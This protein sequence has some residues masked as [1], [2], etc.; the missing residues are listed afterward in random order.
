[1]KQLRL[2]LF[3]CLLTAGLT[4]ISLPAKAAVAETD[5]GIF[6]SIRDNVVTVE[7]FNQ[8]GTVLEV[9]AQIEGLPVRYVAPYACRGNTAITEVRLPDSLLSIGEF[10]FADC[11]NLLKV[12]LQGGES[13]GFSAFRNCRVLATLSLP[14]TLTVIDDEAFYGCT[15]LSFARIP[16]SVSIIGVDAFAGCDRLRLD[17]SDN[18]L[19]ATYAKQYRIPTRFTETPTFTAILILAASLALSVGYL[20]VRRFFPTR[21]PRGSANLPQHK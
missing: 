16:A 12:T 3:L 14:D 1:M 6:Y 15:R 18:A 19:A 5:S 10:A 17:V 13:I 21:K 9:P 11:P 4:V 7:G 8:V 2:F 20:L